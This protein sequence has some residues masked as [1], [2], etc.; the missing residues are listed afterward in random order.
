MSRSE[1][2]LKKA[3]A[4]IRALRDEFYS[5]VRVPEQ[6]TSSIQNWIRRT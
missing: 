5:D 4:D 6:R 3:I 1:A 2:G